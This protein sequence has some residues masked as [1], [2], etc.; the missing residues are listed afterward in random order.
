MQ[1]IKFSLLM[2]IALIPQFGLSLSSS[3]IVSDSIPLTKI[4]AG[5]IIAALQIGNE[6]K[7]ERPKLIELITAQQDLIRTKD[8]LANTY[9]TLYE[10]E[11]LKSNQKDKIIHL[12]D[13]N[14]QRVE[15]DNKRLNNRL[16]RRR[17]WAIVIN[18]IC[19][20][21]GAGAAFIILR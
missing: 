15:K 7:K 9:K 21:L 6:L 10:V 1:F 20:V 18:A 5:S 13:Q 12:Q 2:L 19:V 16:I 17:K 3:L 4:E 8:S 11:Q 14:Y